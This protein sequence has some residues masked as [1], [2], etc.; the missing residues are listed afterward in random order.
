MFRDESGRELLDVEDGVIADADASAPIRFLP[1]YDN[2][3]LSHGDRSRILVDG[4]K[5]EDLVWKGGVLVDGYLGAAWRIRRDKKVATMTVTLYVPVSG[6]QRAEI[7]AEGERLFTFLASDADVDA[8][9]RDIH[10]V[11]ADDQP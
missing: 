11:A 6:E 7:E 1:Q 10:L 9:R 4:L 8:D 2:V 3:F 5:I